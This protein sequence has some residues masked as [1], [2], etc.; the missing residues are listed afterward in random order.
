[1]DNAK[2]SLPAQGVLGSPASQN[3]CLFQRNIRLLKL[4]WSRLCK[5][6]DLEQLM[7]SRSTEHRRRRAELDADDE[8]GDAGDDDM[9]EDA[10]REPDPEGSIEKYIAGY[11]QLC[12]PVFIE[13]NHMASGRPGGHAVHSHHIEA[14]DPQGGGQ[15][16]RNRVSYINVASKEQSRPWTLSSMTR[17]TTP[18]EADRSS[19]Q[20]V[21]VVHLNIFS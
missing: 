15:D 18:A 20:T 11:A 3:V 9:D 16:L 7:S 10:P 12:P 13:L 14:R 5:M 2:E 4:L 6:R 17:R 1:M 21:R 19:A 8:D